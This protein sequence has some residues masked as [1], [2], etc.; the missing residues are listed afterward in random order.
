MFTGSFYGL[1]LGQA[2]LYHLHPQLIGQNS[3]PWLLPNCKKGNKMQSVLCSR[4]EEEIDFGEHVE[5]STTDGKT[6]FK[7]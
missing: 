3:V 6:V 5:V 2:Y 7:K 1:D 4:G